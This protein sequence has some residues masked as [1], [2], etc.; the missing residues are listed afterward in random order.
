MGG[1]T[2]YREK[3]DLDISPSYTVIWKSLCR[4]EYKKEDEE[5]LYMEL[6]RA[7]DVTKQYGLPVFDKACGILTEI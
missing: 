3:I 1:G 2:V 4:L 6:E 5:S 7:L